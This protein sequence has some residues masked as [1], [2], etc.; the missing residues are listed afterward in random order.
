[1]M[2][3]AA[4]ALKHTLYCTVL[5]QNSSTGGEGVSVP[6]PLLPTFLPPSSP[7]HFTSVEKLTTCS[8]LLGGQRA[9]GVGCD[10]PGLGTKSLYYYYSNA[11]IRAF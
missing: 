4:A 8:I 6:S 7:L 10:L 5:G 9:P 3:H 11:D 2:S 1:M